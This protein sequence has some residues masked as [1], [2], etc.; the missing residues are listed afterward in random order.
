VKRKPQGGR[1]EWPE[2]GWP[3]AGALAL[4]VFVVVIFLLIVFSIV[5]DWSPNGEGEA[6][7]I[8][9]EPSEGSGETD[10][11]SEP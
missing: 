4:A 6:V 9:T 8:L 10:A 2:S 11:S 1:I 7:P 5:G 3:G